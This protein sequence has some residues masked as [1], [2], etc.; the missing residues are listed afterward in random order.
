V[1]EVRCNEG[2]QLVE[3]HSATVSL[4]NREGV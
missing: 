4:Q 3:N 1:I 2:Y